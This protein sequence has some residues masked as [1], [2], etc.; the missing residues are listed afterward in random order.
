MCQNVVPANCIHNFNITKLKKLE[1]DVLVLVAISKK[2]LNSTESLFHCNQ[3][4]EMRLLVTIA[5]QSEL[6]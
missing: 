2:K 3:Q 1:H 4:L 6:D 5:Q